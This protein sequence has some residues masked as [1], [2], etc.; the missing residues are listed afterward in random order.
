MQPPLEAE[1]KKHLIVDFFKYT[2]NGKKLYIW[3]SCPLPTRIQHT[4]AWDMCFFFKAHGLWKKRCFTLWGVKKLWNVW[5]LVEFWT[6]IRFLIKGN[7]RILSKFLNEEDLRYFF[8]K[9]W[10]QVLMKKFLVETS[11]NES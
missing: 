7:L 11:S 4:P 10:L 9:A 5:R 2:Y 8:C 6:E 3:A 1:H